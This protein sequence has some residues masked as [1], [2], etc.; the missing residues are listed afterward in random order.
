MLP[1]IPLLTVMVYLWEGRK[2]IVG[3]IL[4]F[5]SSVGVALRKGSK[6]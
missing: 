6:L 3:E 2:E 1:F 4:H 5:Y